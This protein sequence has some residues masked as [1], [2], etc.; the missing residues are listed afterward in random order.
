MRNIYNKSWSNGEKV[1]SD[2]QF[3][4]EVE[5]LRKSI[6]YKEGLIRGARK[7]YEEFNG[8][9]GFR[10][11]GF[12]DLPTKQEDMATMSFINRLETT[13]SEIKSCISSF[14]FDIEKYLTFIPTS[15]G[16]KEIK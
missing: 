1:I 7:R 11:V 3:N 14:G 6:D 15:E 8:V 16:K 13:I 2:T 4:W 9:D 12:S 5:I 10:K